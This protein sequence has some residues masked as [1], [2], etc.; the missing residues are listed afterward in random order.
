MCMQEVN[1]SVKSNKSIVLWDIRRYFFYSVGRKK[2][3]GSFLRGLESGKNHA[4]CFFVVVL[5]PF[6]KYKSRIRN[7]HM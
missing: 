3:A 2:I 6:L 4:F 1:Q 7:W 5:N